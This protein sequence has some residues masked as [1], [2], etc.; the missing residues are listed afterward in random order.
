MGYIKSP[1]NYTGGKYK[2]LDQI[3]PLFPKSVN[4]F[5]DIFGGGFNV[6]VNVNAEEVL[7]NDID[8][9]VANIMEHFATLQ[10]IDV[11][12]R[13]KD[14]IDDY[15]LYFEVDKATEEEIEECKQ[16]YRELRDDY[17]VD[18]VDDDGVYDKD[19]WDKLFALITCSFSNSI[20]RNADGCFNTSYGR[21]CL[22][23][24]MEKNLMNFLVR[25]H[26]L[27]TCVTSKDFR[28]IDYSQF[29][30]G[31]FVYFDP[32]Y[33]NTDANYNK[34]WGIEEE[35]ALYEIFNELSERG[36]KCAISNDLTPNHM[37]EKFAM[38]NGYTIHRLK[39]DYSGC[40]SAK[41]GKEQETTREVL[42][43]NYVL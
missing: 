30:E 2:L 13:V 31:D 4:K 14:V 43:T 28:E 32:P 40:A 34:G 35:K 42:V 33:L 16:G 29:E 27:D 24:T 15:G 37:L 10:P 3:I 7:Y 22:N 21:R 1:L 18:R 6:G 12:S 23:K 8:F 36:V 39:Y 20:S 19:T 17:N 5:A 41:G 9:E 25:M 11:I 26:R 38:D